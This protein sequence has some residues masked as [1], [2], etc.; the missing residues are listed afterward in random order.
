[1]EGS[2]GTRRVM[3]MRQSSTKRNWD[4]GFWARSLIKE[5]SATITTPFPIDT[6]KKEGVSKAGSSCADVTQTTAAPFLALDWIAVA[7]HPGC[8]FARLNGPTMR[9]RP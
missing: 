2:N 9:S 3:A 5:G 1:M 7:S 6:E 4:R 8:G